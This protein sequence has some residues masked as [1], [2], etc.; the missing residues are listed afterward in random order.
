MISDRE[1][2]ACANQVLE[3]HGD[4]ADKFVATRIRSLAAAND[5]AGVKT[6]MA[7]ADRLDRLRLTPADPDQRH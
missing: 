1:L 5:E 7:I 6:W 4:A 2:W 3:Q